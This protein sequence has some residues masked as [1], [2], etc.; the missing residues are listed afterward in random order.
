MTYL[1]PFIGHHNGDIVGK[2]CAETGKSVREAMLE[3]SLLSAAQLGD[4]FSLQN[5]MHPEYKAK[6]YPDD[7]PS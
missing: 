7:T 6:R 1:N 4:I 2:I 3:R 5:L